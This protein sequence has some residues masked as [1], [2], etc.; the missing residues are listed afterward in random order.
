MQYFTRDSKKDPFLGEI[1][2]SLFGCFGSQAACGVFR[3]IT[4]SNVITASLGKWFSLDDKQ[5]SF[6]RQGPPNGL[7]LA[8]TT[9]TQRIEAHTVLG[10]I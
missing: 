9:G 5:V 10:R 6:G 2:K 1:E 8:Q 7:D 4:L 3:G